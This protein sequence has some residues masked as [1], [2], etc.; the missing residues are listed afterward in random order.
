[1]PTRKQIEHQVISILGP[2][3]QWVDLT[4]RIGS[5]VAVTDRAGQR[6]VVKSVPT[7]LSFARELNVYRNWVP[8]FADQAPALKHAL[9]RLRTLIVEHV[10]GENDPTF[11]PED[12]AAAGRLLQRIHTA[13]PPRR[14]RPGG[15]AKTTAEKLGATLRGLPDPTL[16]DREERLFLRQGI[17][18]LRADFGHLPAVPCHGDFGPHN[19][20]RGQDRVRAIDFSLSRFN[21]AAADFARLYMGPWW[22]RP[23]LAEAFFAGY[24]RPI[25]EEEIECVRRI[26]PVLAAGLI[27][28]GHRH[29][30]AAMEQRGRNRLRRLAEGYDFTTPPGRVPLPRR[31]VRRLTR[32]SNPR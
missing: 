30:D 17:R 13:A 29:G 10:E 25:T 24:G 11:D 28:F 21:A 18:E 7:R 27:R 8:H 15:V 4:R 32:R 14:H 16:I 23:H 1:M 2:V 26:L 5:V 31:V 20:I 3:H 9:P 12:H 6:W 22:E 19:W